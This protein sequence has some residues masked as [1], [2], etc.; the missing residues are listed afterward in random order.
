MFGGKDQNVEAQS[1]GQTRAACANC[2]KRGTACSFHMCT[3]QP[4][5]NSAREE[6]TRQGERDSREGGRAT[7]RRLAQQGWWAG[8]EAGKE[9]GRGAARQR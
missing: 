1:E 8:R 9:A 4:V 3:S 2:R 5:G 7:E 6:G